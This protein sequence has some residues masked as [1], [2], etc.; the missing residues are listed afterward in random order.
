MLRSVPGDQAVCMTLA[1][2]EGFLTSRDR[3]PAQHERADDK[4]AGCV[5]APELRRGL[6]AAQLQIGAMNTHPTEE[7]ETTRDG[8]LSHVDRTRLE[9][10]LAQCPSCGPATQMARNDVLPA[11]AS[12]R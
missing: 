2:H 3:A 7:N 12:L 10:D 11:G 6:S 4:V 9:S 8:E 1:L 5:R